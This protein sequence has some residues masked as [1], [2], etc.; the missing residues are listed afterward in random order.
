MI[1][2]LRVTF[3]LFQSKIVNSKQTHPATGSTVVLVSPSIGV[4]LLVA[5][6]LAGFR[7]I[8]A[9]MATT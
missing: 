6:F 9:G 5:Q 2:A 3:N 1:A 8:K 4:W 7:C